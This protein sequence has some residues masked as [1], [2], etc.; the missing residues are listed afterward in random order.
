ML[1]LRSSH[2]GFNGFV[3]RTLLHITG[4]EDKEKWPKEMLGR[5]IP[6]KIYFDLVR[7]RNTHLDYPDFHGKLVRKLKL[8]QNSNAVD[9]NND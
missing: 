6:R 5:E 8:A 7:Y 3:K 9:W 1:N 4:V 2:N